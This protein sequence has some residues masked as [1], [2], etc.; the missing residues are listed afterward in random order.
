MKQILRI[1]GYTLASFI[2]IVLLYIIASYFL[3]RISVGNGSEGND[4]VLYIL[5]NGVHTDIVVPMKNDQC[6]W[7][8]FISINDI[9]NPQ[10]DAHYIAFGW[11][12]KGFYLETPTWAELKF[13][14][15]FKAIT[16][17]GGSAMHTTYYDELQENEQCIKV[18][19]S[20]HQYGKL[21]T[22][23]KESFITDRNGKAIKVPNSEGY[24][25][26]DCFYEAK[27]SYSLF[28]TCN[29]WANSALKE[30]GLQAALWTPFDKGILYHYKN[31]Q[32]SE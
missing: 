18:Q 29:S 28:K 13:S 27:G 6:N 31:L 24:G 26:Y 1:L 20:N 15:A 16:G 32:T 17:L 25:L 4:V 5:S 3:S 8:E 19:V 11:G 22:Y 21:V 23:I 10:Y 9:P 7:Q 12:D 2:G 30:C 14:V